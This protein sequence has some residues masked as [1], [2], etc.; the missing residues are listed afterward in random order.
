M[1][2]FELFELVKKTKPFDRMHYPRLEGASEDEVAAFAVTH[3]Q[4]HFVET[5]GSLA[6]LSGS[7]HHGYA[8][9]RPA[10]A[11]IILSTLIHAACLADVIGLDASKLEEE[12]RRLP[13]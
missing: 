13:K 12:I 3:V 2:L 10:V 11:R 1:E 5:A 9:D 7:I 4:T 8:L 6:A